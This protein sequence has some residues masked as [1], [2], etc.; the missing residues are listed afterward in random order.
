MRRTTR[1]GA[2]ACAVLLLP[3]LAACSA[4]EPE[5]PRELTISDAGG[6]Y[7][8]A[9][10]PVN[11][12]WDLADVEVDRLRLAVARG[13][14]DADTE[15]F[16]DAIR[17]VAQADVA[18]AE[19]LGSERQIWPEH[20]ADAVAAVVETLE[21]ERA[22]ARRVA[23]LDAEEIAAYEWAGAAESAAASAAARKALELPDDGAAACA[24]WAEQRTGESDSTEAEDD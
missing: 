7:L 23:K 20:A 6:V 19:R 8:E 13:E 3:A 4:P 12:A 11:D 1:Y 2:A 10:C 22:Q 21:A 15:P 5:P 17:T 24:R 18:A 16:A 14:V 9:V